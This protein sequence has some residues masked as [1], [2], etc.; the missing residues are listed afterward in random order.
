MSLSP[1]HF[2]PFF[3]FIKRG[4]HA[5]VWQI[6]IW[7]QLKY[8]KDM[9]TIN[10]FQEQN[11]KRK[12]HASSWGT[13]KDASKLDS[14]TALVNLGLLVSPWV[15]LVWA[16]YFQGIIFRLWRITLREEILRGQNWDW[17][18]SQ[19]RQWWER[20]WEVE[21]FELWKCLWDKITDGCH[22]YS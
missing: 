10:Y 21:I 9:K 20:W 1:Y 3:T 17:K 7:K 18:S 2:S 6:M 12:L 15:I 13:G 4:E 19:W 8:L 14:F 5:N 11:G 22:C 16:Q